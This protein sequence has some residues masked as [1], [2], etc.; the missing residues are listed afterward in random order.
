M[1]DSI[2][3]TTYND[4]RYSKTLINCKYLN[5]M[6]VLEIVTNAFAWFAYKMVKL[7]FGPMTTVGDDCL[8]VGDK[9]S[10]WVT[11]CK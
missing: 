6:K 3:I 11:C 7:K 5:R 8:V 10:V 1:N 2:N 4:Q 9:S